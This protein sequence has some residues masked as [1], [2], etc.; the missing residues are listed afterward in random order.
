[1]P[2]KRGQ[3]FAFWRKS[4]DRY[5][6]NDKIWKLYFVKKM[7]CSEIA[8][9]IDISISQISRIVRKNENYMCEKKRRKEESEKRHREGKR[10]SK[11]K[12]RNSQ[13]NEKASMDYL[14]NQASRILSGRKTINN[15]AFK[16]WN[17]SIYEYDGETSEYRIEEALEDKVSYAAPRKIKWK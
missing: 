6:R 10:K 9:E 11:M 8:K 12:K 2:K 14:H 4:M 3:I 16:K 1:M 5:T 13:I 17:S 7:T 15:R